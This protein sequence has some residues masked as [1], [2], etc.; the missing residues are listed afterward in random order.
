[1]KDFL[2]NNYSF[3]T[4]LVEFL[5]ALTGLLFYKKYKFTAAKY[6]IW[7]LVYVVFFDTL[8]GYTR[9]VHPDRFLSFLIDTPFEKNH[10][11][12]T[13]YWDI[14]AIIFFVFYYNKILKTNRFK[15]VLKYSA[16]LFLGISIVQI[17]VGWQDFFSKFF[18]VIILAGAV[19]IFEGTVLYFV[20]VL[21]SDKI[22][23][24]YR[25]L[26]FYISSAIFIWWLIITPF[27]FY[28]VYVTY[29]VV[30]RY[31]DIDFIFLKWQIFL[32]SNIFMYSTFIFA[33]IFCKPGTEINK[34][35][36]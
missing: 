21:K 29:E 25:S 6:F 8:S 30:G 12:G 9:Y 23:T 31:Q 2:L 3:I 22:L 34:T 16:Y 26:S 27:T 1:M 10:W 32:F 11:L 13:I 18:S 33:L 5:A 36:G 15:I 4:H 24:F 28:D 17:I 7:F 20:E 19:V 14:G 35:D